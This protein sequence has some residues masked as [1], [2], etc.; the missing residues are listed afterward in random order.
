L[1]KKGFYIFT[2]FNYTNENN[3]IE[4]SKIQEKLKRDNIR[5]KVIRFLDSISIFDSLIVLSADI[6][7]ELV[8]Q[9]SK[10]YKNNFY[11]VNNVG[12]I[13]EFD[14]KSDF[15]MNKLGKLRENFK[16]PIRLISDNKYW[17]IDIAG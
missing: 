17:G 16:S 11:Y 13:F 12:F 4:L 6:K 1:I 15:K 2:V 9:I 3:S 10:K 7:Y 5:C 8:K 14:F